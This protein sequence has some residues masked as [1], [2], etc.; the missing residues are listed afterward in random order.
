MKKVMVLSLILLVIYVY[1]GYK[2][3]NNETNNLNEA[4]ITTFVTSY[5]TMIHNV[6]YENNTVKFSLE[7]LAPY[8]TSEWYQE[9]V[10][11]EYIYKPSDFAFAKQKNIQLTN[12]DITSI[13][14]SDDVENA[15]KVSYVLTVDING[16]QVK[17]NGHMTLI[18]DENS[19]KPYVIAKDWE[20]SVVIDD[21][22]LYY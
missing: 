16:E 13:S 19:Q 3:M 17:K 1:T 4:E 11:N 15:Y 10:K 18:H 8:F 6:K 5:K 2:L 12:I 21:G 9:N 22:V 20:E 7:K 14:I